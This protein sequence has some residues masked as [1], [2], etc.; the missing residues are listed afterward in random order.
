MPLGRNGPSPPKR[1]RD[2]FDEEDDDYNASDN[3]SDDEEELPRKL[4]ER[5]LSDVRRSPSPEVEDEEEKGENEKKEEGEDEEG[6]DEEEAW[7]KVI[8]E[9]GE[10]LEI[11]NLTSEE[12]EVLFREPTLS[13][14]T[15]PEIINVVVAVFN[16]ASTLENSRLY[17]R[18]KAKIDQLEDEGYPHWEAQLSAWNERK[19]LVK[20]YFLTNVLNKKEQDESE[21]EGED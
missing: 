12:A 14:T 18:I 4:R 5:R 11:E 3:E 6:D 10:K 13:N 21:D 9:V 20:E 2:V 8:M 7:H 16:Q 17:T 19:F 15:I 1:V